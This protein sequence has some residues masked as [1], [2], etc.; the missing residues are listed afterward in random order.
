MPWATS[1]RSSP[2][3]PVTRNGRSNWT[4][5]ECGNDGA[6]GPQAFRRMRPT[7]QSQPVSSRKERERVAV[8]QHD[9]ADAARSLDRLLDRDARAERVPDELRT[10][11]SQPV[12]EAVEE[13]E[14]AGHRR[15]HVALGVAER[16]QVERED[17]VAA[18]R[19]QRPDAVPDPARLGGAAEQHDRGPAT[20]PAP[21]GDERR[22]DTDE[23]SAVELRRRPCCAHR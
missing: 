10:H 14:P 11:D 17:A 3:V 15:R 12:L 19:E 7:S 20:A 5:V 8:E 6:P 23:R 9:P 18:G 21:V 1:A 22:A 4:S 13:R 2:A 16:R